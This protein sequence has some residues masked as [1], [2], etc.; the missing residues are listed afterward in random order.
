MSPKSRPPKIAAPLG[1]LLHDIKNRFGGHTLK[2]NQA[3]R[4][5]ELR[6]KTEDLALR[7]LSLTPTSRE[8]SLAITRLEEVLFWATEAIARRERGHASDCAVHNAPAS[9]AGPCNCEEV[10]P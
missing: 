8:Q 5:A 10:T 9:P 7:I 2:G 4:W 1:V 6:E 3:D